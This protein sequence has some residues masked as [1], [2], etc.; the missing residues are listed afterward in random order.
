MTIKQKNLA[1][2]AIENPTLPKGKLV[3]LGSY[4]KVVQSQPGK[5]LDSVG[6]KQAL[7]EYG[8][9]EELITSS[10]VYDINAK[11]KRR[12]REL[13]LGSDILGMRKRAEQPNSNQVIIVNISQEAVGKY[14]QTT[15]TDAT[16]I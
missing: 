9:T 7:A 6:Y 3:E 16:T 11:P 8:L 4:G 13:E 12:V 5:V 15:V 10:L 1:R 14:G 2:L